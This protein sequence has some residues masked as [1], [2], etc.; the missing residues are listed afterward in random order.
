MTNNSCLQ[1]FTIVSIKILF[2]NCEC[3]CC[4]LNIGS[5][6]SIIESVSYKCSSPL[7]NFPAVESDANNGDDIDACFVELCGCDVRNTPDAPLTYA[8]ASMLVLLV[9]L[10]SVLAFF[11]H[12]LNLQ[13]I[14]NYCH[15]QLNCFQSL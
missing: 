10:V 8:I 4:S 1:C 12:P 3:C 6:T 2:R 13:L 11:L 15:Y 5:N 14:L 7:F 9:F